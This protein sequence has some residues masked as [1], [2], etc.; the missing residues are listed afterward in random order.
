[1][2]EGNCQ[3]IFLYQQCYINIKYFNFNIFHKID[4]S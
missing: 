2:K 1:M 4:V 3:K